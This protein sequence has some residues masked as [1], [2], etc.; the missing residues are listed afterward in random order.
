MPVFFTNATTIVYV[1]LFL[2]GAFLQS[3]F[4]E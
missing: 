2:L 4:S 1:L 3:S